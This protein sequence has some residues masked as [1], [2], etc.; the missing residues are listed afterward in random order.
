MAA[1]NRATFVS[2]GPEGSCGTC[3]NLNFEASSP[4]VN[5]PRSVM[6]PVM[7]SATGMSKARLKKA[8]SGVSSLV[9]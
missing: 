9:S 8:A 5:T 2:R 3:H 4:G 6:M 7:R 1:P